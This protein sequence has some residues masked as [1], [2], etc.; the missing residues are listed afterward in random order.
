[1][2]NDSCPG[3]AKKA[4]SFREGFLKPET[5]EKIRALDEIAS[6]RGQSLPQMA[7][8]WT[9]REQAKGQQVTTALIGAS[10][11]DQIRECVRCLDNLE[12][13]PEELDRIDAH[14]TD[15][16]INIWAQS[17]ET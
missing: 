14:A 9:L 13:T 11:A 4:P 8:A 5:I 2:D 10:S 7:I 17:S 12:F 15:A 16:G 3:S 6:A 1:M